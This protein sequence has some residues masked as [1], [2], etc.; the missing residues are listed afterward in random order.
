MP[1]AEAGCN[2]CCGLDSHH[3]RLVHDHLHVPGLDLHVLAL[4]LAYGLHGRLSLTHP[5]M[6]YPLEEPQSFLQYLQIRLDVQEVCKDH[7]P[8]HRS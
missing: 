3:V 1:V 7:R 6:T 4:F 5:V 2:H 8:L